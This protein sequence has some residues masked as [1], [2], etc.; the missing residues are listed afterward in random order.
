[1]HS[2]NET[3][4]MCDVHMCVFDVRAHACAALHVHVHGQWKRYMLCY[5]GKHNLH[6][7]PRAA[8]VIAQQITA[9]HRYLVGRAPPIRCQLMCKN[10]KIVENVG[11]KHEL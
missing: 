11:A 6:T 7:M 9:L 3:H 5:I 2:P 1:M 8:S 10:E 4:K